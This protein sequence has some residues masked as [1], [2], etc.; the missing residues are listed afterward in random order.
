VATVG[1]GEKGGIVCQVAGRRPLATGRLVEAGNDVR[2]LEDP[3]RVGTCPHPEAAPSAT[4]D[5]LHEIHALCVCLAEPLREE[6]IWTG[7]RI[8]LNSL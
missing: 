7:M 5:S 6:K 3:S 1:A 4:D 8:P 2:G